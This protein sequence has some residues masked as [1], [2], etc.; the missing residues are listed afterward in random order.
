MQD[1]VTR[2][3]QALD[4]LIAHDRT[5]ELAKTVTLLREA[6]IDLNSLAAS[7]LDALRLPPRRS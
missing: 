5:G 4:E 3:N 1:E 2:L 6:G 7:L